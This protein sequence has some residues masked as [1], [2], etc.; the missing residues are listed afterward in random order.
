MIASGYKLKGFAFVILGMILI[1]QV[2]SVD[3]GEYNEHYS[4]ENN[5]NSDNLPL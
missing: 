3:A 4:L 5:T 1:A 2:P